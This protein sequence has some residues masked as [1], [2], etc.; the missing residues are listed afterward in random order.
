[1]I[2]NGEDATSTLLGVG[3]DGVLV[4]GLDGE[5]VQD[6]NSFDTMLLTRKLQGRKA[7]IQMKRDQ[8]MFLLPLSTTKSGQSPDVD[9]VLFFQLLRGLK[10]LIQG[11]SS[12]DDK[13]GIRVGLS[14]NFSLSNLGQHKSKRF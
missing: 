8:K 5:W 9:S 3:N 4:D 12:R 10:G 11:N 2:L 6:P 1:M 13:D 7:T 14:D